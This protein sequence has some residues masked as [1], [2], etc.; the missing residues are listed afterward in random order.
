MK[1]I[2]GASHVSLN[3]YSSFKYDNKQRFDTR[4]IDGGFVIQENMELQLND[5]QILYN[6]DINILEIMIKLILMGKK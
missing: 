6:P 1:D 2:D 4:D 3:H 5:A